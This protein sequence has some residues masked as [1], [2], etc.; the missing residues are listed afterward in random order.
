MRTLQKSGGIASILEALIYIVAF[1]IYGAILEYPPTNAS[2]QQE[3]TFLSDN[4]VI[5]SFLNLLM[6]VIFGILLSILVLAL[7]KRIKEH[8]PDLSSIASVFGFLWVGLVI[9]SGMIGNIGLSKVIEIGSNDP[10]QAMQIWSTVTIVTEGLG[11]GNEIVGGI[12]VL[13]LSIAA[14]KGKSLP[15]SL[16]YLGLIVGLAGIATVYPAEIFTEVF[17]ITQIIWFLWLGI[18]MLKS[19]KFADP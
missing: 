14:L 6:Y 12:W 13:L 8:T 11:G 15:K 9:A 2:S 7:H 5:F 1:I 4:Q 3:L 18:F 10:E 17:G 19:A 16:N